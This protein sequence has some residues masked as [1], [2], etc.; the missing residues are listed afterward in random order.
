MVLYCIVSHFLFFLMIRRPPRSTRTDTLFPYTTLF[1][2][3]EV[4]VADLD[5][6]D[7]RVDAQ[8]AGDAQR[9]VAAPI[10]DRV[11]QRIG[12]KTG[13]LHP[14]AQGG[15]AGEGAVTHVGPVAPFLVRAVGGEEVLRVPGR[16][17]RPDGIGRA[18]V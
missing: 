4:D 10:D 13:L 5:D 18:H 11:E 7:G 17:E 3:A 8:V 9:L 12:A 15:G 1:R 2:S 14:L 6:A 16:V